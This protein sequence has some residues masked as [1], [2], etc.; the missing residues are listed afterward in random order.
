MTAWYWNPS[1]GAYDNVTAIPAGGSVWII[2]SAPSSVTLTYAPSANGRT[3]TTTEI[4]FLPAGPITI[5]VG[6]SI[7][8]NLS[9]ATLDKA[10]YDPAYL[11]LDTA[12]ES[13]D[14][15]CLNDPSCAVSLI[16]QFW[17][18]HAIAAGN[19]TITVTP[20]CVSVP[21]CAAPS[22]RIAV[23]ILP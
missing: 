4:D 19:T 1:R 16:N 12:G 23:S 10:T 5:H 20:V 2:A 6:D 14:L 7:K 17:V 18:W 11:H 21:T 22:S 13:G 8:L 3:P 9:L 15:S